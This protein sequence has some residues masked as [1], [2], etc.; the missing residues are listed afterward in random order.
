MP[1]VQSVM[2][3]FKISAPELPEIEKEIPKNWPGKN[4]EES[5][6]WGQ[7][8]FF[9]DG[10]QSAL[11]RYKNKYGDLELYITGG[12]AET[13]SELISESSKKDLFLIFKGMEAIFNG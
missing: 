11:E 4:T 2:N 6:Q 8:G 13:I 12:D 10:V 9:I 3:I 5:L 1:G 7:I